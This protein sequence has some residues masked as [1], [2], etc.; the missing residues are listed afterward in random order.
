MN[1]RTACGVDISPRYKPVT[2]HPS[3]LAANRVTV[4]ATS[5]EDAGAYPGDLN[6][7]RPLNRI[8]IRSRQHGGL[9]SRASGGR[10]NGASRWGKTIFSK[11]VSAMRYISVISGV[12]AALA[13]ALTANAGSFED[14]AQVTVSGAKYKLNG[15]IV[16]IERDA[17][18]IRK[19]SGDIVRVAATEGTQASEPIA[20]REVDVAIDISEQS[21]SHHKRGD[22]AWLLLSWQGCRRSFNFATGISWRM[23]LCPH[24]SAMSRSA[25]RA[26]PHFVKTARASGVRIDPGQ[27]VTLEFNAPVANG[28]SIMAPRNPC[29]MSS[30]A[31]SMGR[32]MD[33]RCAGNC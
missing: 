23:S 31:M 24:C 2:L 15:P 26:M 9:Y 30:G 4:D 7:Y 22:G 13:F 18:W 5:T 16:K 17:Y 8:D 28:G 19:A 6:H 20:A 14:K 21:L 25:F 12:V 27:T 10:K 33:K 1:R 32:S 11:E 3:R 29:M